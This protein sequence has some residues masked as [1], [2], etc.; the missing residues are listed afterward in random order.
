METH[1]SVVAATAVAVA[2]PEQKWAKWY[3]ADSEINRKRHN[4]SCE[5]HM[6]VCMHNMSA[7]TNIVLAQ[8]SSMWPSYGCVWCAT[9]NWNRNK[10][11]HTKCNFTLHVT[12]LRVM[13]TYI[14]IQSV[15]SAVH[16][17]VHCAGVDKTHAYIPVKWKYLRLCPTH[18]QNAKCKRNKF[19]LFSNI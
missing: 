8:V 10:T 19:R 14:W 16:L 9:S 17:C 18:M 2:A 4:A 7:M 1:R 11:M 6:R 3:A 15:I 13:W 5:W 12:K